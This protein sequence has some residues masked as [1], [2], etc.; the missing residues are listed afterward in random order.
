MNK[1]VKTVLTCFLLGLMGLAFIGA[2]A[3]LAFQ[4]SEAFLACSAVVWSSGLLTIAVYAVTIE[5]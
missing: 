3:A 5:D 4:N 2:M 1:I